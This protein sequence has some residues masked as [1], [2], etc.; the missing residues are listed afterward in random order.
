VSQ[1]RFLFDENIDPDLIDALVRREPSIDVLRVGWEGAPPHGTEDPE[2]L[3]AAVSESRMLV[4]QDRRTMP[5]H[6]RAHFAAGRHT[7]GVAL[8]KR[9]FSFGQYV[10]E[11]L[12]LWVTSSAE[13][14]VDCT[15]YLPL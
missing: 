10:E 8:L 7:H 13:E 2:L 14:W 15:Q 4:S 6:L 5:N 3:I 11:L 1:I 9:G 12:L